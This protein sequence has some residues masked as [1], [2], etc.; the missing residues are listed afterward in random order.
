MG[1][2]APG[3]ASDRRFALLPGRP[4]RAH[5]ARPRERGARSLAVVGEHPRRLGLS[6]DAGAGRLAQRGHGGGC[7]LLRGRPPAG[8]VTTPGSDGL[9]ADR[10]PD[11]VFELDAGC[12]ILSA[13]IA[14]TGLTGCRRDELVGQLLTSVL[15]PRD[16]TGRSLLA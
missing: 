4:H 16:A 14:A 9:D 12:R 3:H 5:R 1:L 7:P 10:L 2:A 11:A 6:S 15:E 8:A 13:N